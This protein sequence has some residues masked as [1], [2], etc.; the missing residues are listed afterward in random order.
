MDNEIDLGIGGEIIK[1]DTVSVFDE[2]ERTDVLALVNELG[3]EWSLEITA[4]EER[5]LFYQRRTV[6]DALELGKTLL[7]LK[8]VTEHGDFQDRV[9]ALGFSSRSAR[10]FMMASARVAKSAS[11]ALLAKQ[12]RSMKG[13]LELL[14]LEDDDIQNILELDDLDRMSA[15]QLREI[16]RKLRQDKDTAQSNLNTANARLERLQR[17]IAIADPSVPKETVIARAY[18]MG[19]TKTVEVKLDG[20]LKNFAQESAADTE[21]ARLRLEQEWI[22]ANVIAAR[23]LDVIERMR[24]LAPFQLPERVFG[25]HILTPEEAERWRRDAILIENMEG[26]ERMH[27]EE[28]EPEKR[29]R[30]RPRKDGAKA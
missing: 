6:E 21:D 4:L 19:A 29:G 28:G 10:R 17:G 23:A 14:T 12:V 25:Q 3:Y 22:A 8:A 1:T 27:L 26:M 2:G 30:G 7:V 18:C 20:L 16:A 24:E 5:I 11:A 13:F 15:S 9:E